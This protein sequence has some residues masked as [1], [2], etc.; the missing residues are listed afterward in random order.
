MINKYQENPAYGG[1]DRS[2]SVFTSYRDQNSNLNGN[3]KTFYV[4]ADMPFYLW[5]GALGFSLYNQKIG[6][7]N[8]TNIKLSYNYVA[9]TN[10][11]FL[12]FGGRLGL[13][14]LTV[15][16]NGIITPDGN[17][18]G[19]FNH[20]DPTLDI[21]RFNGYGL[22]WELGTYFYNNLFEA[23]L[24]LSEVPTHG[25]TLGN[26]TYNRAFTG[27]L[28]GLYKYDFSDEIRITP[29]ILIKADAAVV[30]T[31]LSI[32]AKLKDNLT[33]GASLRGY[34]VSSFD[35]LA[36]ILGTNLG[37]KYNIFYSYDFGLSKLRSVHQGSHE[38]MLSYNLQ[39]LIGIGLPPKIIYNPRDL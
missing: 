16:G 7:F 2:L 24:V 38:I 30:Q 32:L 10:F 9:S 5:N 35:A 26:G 8:N 28:F 22:S 31:D 3:P 33:F 19:T 1:L 13:D 25:Y 18:E 29:S 14:M 36:V 23:G 12:S 21:N 4:G 37:K 17:Y 6:V 27:S 11:G 15:N 20:N 39:R 34:S